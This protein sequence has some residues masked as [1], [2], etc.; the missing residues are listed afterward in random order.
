MKKTTDGIKVK[1]GQEINIPHALYNVISIKKSRI[2]ANLAICNFLATDLNR[3]GR[4]Q[5]ADGV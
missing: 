5:H 4:D 1:A 2:V 3:E